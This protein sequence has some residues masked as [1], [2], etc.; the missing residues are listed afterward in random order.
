[1]LLSYF[2]FSPLQCGNH[3]IFPLY[4]SDRSLV[5]YFSENRYVSNNEIFSSVCKSERI[6]FLPLRN[7]DSPILTQVDLLSNLAIRIRR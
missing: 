4:N 3:L 1:M 2:Q 5:I 6:N 7:F